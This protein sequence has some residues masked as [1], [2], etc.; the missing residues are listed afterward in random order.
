MNSCEQSRT[1]AQS[2]IA[3][4]EIMAAQS[5]QPSLILKGV[6]IAMGLASGAV[7]AERVAGPP[8]GPDAG[9]HVAIHGTLDVSQEDD[10]DHGRTDRHYSVV[11]QATGKQFGLRFGTLKPGKNH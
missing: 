5:N 9:R 3:K 4:E 10:F 1:L 7:A 2:D 8:V 6:A 11:D